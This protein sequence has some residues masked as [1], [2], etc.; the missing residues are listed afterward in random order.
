MGISVSSMSLKRTF[1]K[2]KRKTMLGWM[3]K[4]NT[5]YQTINQIP[6]LR[7]TETNLEF[8]FIGHVTMG[9]V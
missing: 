9:V 6:K 1:F 7:S 4:T 3:Q 5:N 2:I 8:S